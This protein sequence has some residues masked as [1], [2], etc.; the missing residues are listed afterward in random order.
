[1]HLPYQAS[2]GS[3]VT[4]CAVLMLLCVVCTV[5]LEWQRG[6]NQLYF[7]SLYL[8]YCHNA[9]QSHNLFNREV[10]QNKSVATP[11]STEPKNIYIISTLHIQCLAPP[12]ALKSTSRHSIQNSEDE[13][14]LN[15]HGTACGSL[16]HNWQWIWFDTWS[17]HY[18]SL[19]E[20]SLISS[21]GP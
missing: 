1:M 12:A 16:L 14:G 4:D 20:R 10:I 6:M 7:G 21:S 5:S 11:Q 19:T 15:T 9:K 13:L 8:Q 18:A 17:P 3:G 2:A